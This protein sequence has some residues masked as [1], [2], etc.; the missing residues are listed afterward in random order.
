[1]SLEL[2]EGFISS[3]GASGVAEGSALVSSTSPPGDWY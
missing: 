2:L 1:M 3:L